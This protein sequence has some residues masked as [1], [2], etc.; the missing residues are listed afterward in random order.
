MLP[1]ATHD[2][3]GK[4]KFEVVTPATAATHQGTKLC[5]LYLRRPVDS[6]AWMKAGVFPYICLELALG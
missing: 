4:T 5:N 1:M 3:K 2:E 6:S